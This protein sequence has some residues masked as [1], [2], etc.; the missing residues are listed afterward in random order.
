MQFPSICNH[1]VFGF[2][3]L[4]PF[5][6]FENAWSLVKFQ[7]YKT[8]AVFDMIR[9]AIIKQNVKYFFFLIRRIKILIKIR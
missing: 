8:K 3:R 6:F 4:F 1:K 2:V 5:F 7:G 9:D